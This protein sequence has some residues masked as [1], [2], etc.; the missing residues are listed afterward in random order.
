MHDKVISGG[1]NTE[2]SSD[3]D[4]SVTQPLFMEEHQKP[5]RLQAMDRARNSV[6]NNTMSLSLLSASP[7]TIRM[8]VS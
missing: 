2:S 1:Q 5:A 4:Q 3:M 8:G 7:L 6:L